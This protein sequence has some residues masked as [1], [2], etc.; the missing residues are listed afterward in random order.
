MVLLRGKKLLLHPQQRR[1]LLHGIRQRHQQTQHVSIIGMQQ[2]QRRHYSQYNDLNKYNVSNSNR[3]FNLHESVGCNNGIIISPRY[4][5]PMMTNNTFRTFTT[6]TTAS[7]EEEEKLKRVEEIQRLEEKEE[8]SLDDYDQMIVGYSET[9][10]ITKAHE[11]LLQ[12]EEQDGDL[13]DVTSYN[14]VMNGWLQYQSNL[15]SQLLLQQK[16]DDEDGKNDV[17]IKKEREAIVSDIVKA[18]ENVDLILTRIEELS[19]SSSS[20]STA[21]LPKPTLHHYNSAILAFTNCTSFRHNEEEQSFSPL[22]IPSST[23]RGTPQRAQRILEKLESSPSLPSPTIQSYN[24][25]IEAWSTSTEHHFATMAQRIY[26]RLLH[27][28]TESAAT[29]TGVAGDV[30]PNLETYQS[31]IRAWC[32]SS[33]VHGGAAHWATKILS[34]MLFKLEHEKNNGN[35]KKKDEDIENIE[36]TMEDYRLV[37]ECWSKSRIKNAAARSLSILQKMEH[38]YTSRITNQRPTVECYKQVLVAISKSKMTEIKNNTTDANDS[39]G[40][41]AVKLL[42][43]MEERQIQPDSDCYSAAIKTWC[44]SAISKHRH[45]KDRRKRSKRGEI[46]MNENNDPGIDAGIAHDLLQRMNDMYHKSSIVLVKSTRCN[47]NDVLRAWSI[48]GANDAAERAEELLSEMEKEQKDLAPNKESYI[49]TIESYAKRKNTSVITSDGSDDKV[50]KSLELLQRMMHQYE[51]GNVLARPDTD[52]YNSVLNACA[53]CFSKDEK[54]R[55]NA[56]R[57]AIENV[58]NMREQAKE[59][60]RGVKCK[61]DATTYR[62]LLEACRNLLPAEGGER[63]KAVEAVFNRCCL[64]GYVDT[65]VL[66]VFQKIASP[67]LYR[68]RVLLIVTGGEGGSGESKERTLPEKWTRNLRYRGRTLEGKKA[69]PT[70][71]IDGTFANI[72]EMNQYKMRNLRERKNQRVLRG[73]RL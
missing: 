73:G 55:R 50:E 23:A 32:K 22:M 51:S 15:V 61:P 57:V 52:V 41:C 42:D 2:K 54:I 45:N 72:Q 27:Q 18:A 67:E 28:N 47:Y 1:I 35:R 6:T 69:A 13:P 63:E 59:E 21:V 31:L 12:L 46:K 11:L 14:A 20:E 16:D 58:Q 34:R 37:L 40:Q 62:L 4:D 68:K 26:D 24:L 7:E 29:N 56:M 49:L 3:N 65:E 71:S 43:E 17:D 66:E 10:N 19:S 60:G 38:L 64:E 25:V 8:K 33:N 39:M 53:K 36:P 30:T 48:S 9:D 5:V 44:N 70:L